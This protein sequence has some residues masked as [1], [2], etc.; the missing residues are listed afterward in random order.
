MCSSKTLA[1]DKPPTVR[2]VSILVS[3]ILIHYVLGYMIVSLQEVISDVCLT[4]TKSRKTMR[5]FWQKARASK[6]SKL[7]FTVHDTFSASQ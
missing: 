2:D 1:Q 7:S 4:K 5:S 6:A 3:L